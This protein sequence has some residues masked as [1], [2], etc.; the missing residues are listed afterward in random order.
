MKHFA[1]LYDAIDRTTS[2]NAK[3]AAMVTYFGEAPPTDAAWAVFFL[4][5][6]RLKRLVSHPA[7]R[8]WALAATR[9]DEWLL[10]ECYGVGGGGAGAGGAGL[11]QGA[12]G[13]SENG[14]LGGGGG[15][16]ILPVR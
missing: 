12:G 4:T 14:R 13:V 10:G 9:L 1:A 6:R 5:G 15:G 7:I 8:D 16:G 3:V 11:G 2:T